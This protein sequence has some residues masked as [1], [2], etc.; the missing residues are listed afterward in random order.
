METTEKIKLARIN[1]FVIDLLPPSRSVTI[2]IPV[3]G[4]TALSRR[5]ISAIL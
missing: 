1:W 3:I 2:G 5:I 4:G